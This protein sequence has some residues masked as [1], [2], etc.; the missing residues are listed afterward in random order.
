VLFVS[1]DRRPDPKLALGLSM[2]FGAFL[3]REWCWVATEF[4]HQVESTNLRPFRDVLLGLFLRQHRPC[5]STRR[6]Y[7]HLARGRLCG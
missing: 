1:P 3:A 2:A 4:R 7:G 6:V 5:W